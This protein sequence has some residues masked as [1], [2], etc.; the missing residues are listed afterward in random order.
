M[1]YWEIVAD[2]LSAAGWSWGYCS[3]VTRDGWR[4]I[5]G[6]Y[7]KDGKRCIV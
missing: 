6:A 7:K 3:A 5:V 2:Q 4:W 1:K